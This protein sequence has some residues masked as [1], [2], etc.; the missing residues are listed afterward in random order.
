MKEYPD[1]IV[2]LEKQNGGLADARNYAIPYAKGEYI[3]FW[4]LMIM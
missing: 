3:A 4:I 1:K 2:Y